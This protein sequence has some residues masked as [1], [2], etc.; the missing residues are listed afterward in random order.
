MVAKKN[1]GYFMLFESIL[2]S[3]MIIWLFYRPAVSYLEGG[4][5]LSVSCDELKVS[6]YD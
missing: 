4:A 2:G 6:Q 3:F 5:P 1:R